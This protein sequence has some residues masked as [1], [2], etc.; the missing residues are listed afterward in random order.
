MVYCLI[1]GVREAINPVQDTARDLLHQKAQTEPRMLEFS[2]YKIQ[3]IEQSSKDITLDQ[4]VNTGMSW[5]NGQGVGLE[6]I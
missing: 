1:S 5:Q 3:E 6:I 4:V 2:L